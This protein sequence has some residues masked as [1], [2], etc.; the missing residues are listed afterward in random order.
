MSRD[1]NLQFLASFHTD[2]ACQKTAVKT[3]NSNHVTVGCCNYD[4]VDMNPNHNHMLWEPEFWGPVVILL[5]QHNCN[6]E[7]P[8][9]EQLVS[10]ELSVFGQ[11]VSALTDKT[12]GKMK[13]ELHLTNEFYQ[14][15]NVE[16]INV[17][18]SPI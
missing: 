10:E 4:K 7:Q 17:V 9:N 15:H 12:M 18:T 1:Y 16:N 11:V 2:F 8:L 6:S 5:F 3:T 14:T 13:S